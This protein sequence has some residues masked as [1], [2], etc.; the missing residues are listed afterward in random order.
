L[1][2]LPK[3]TDQSLWSVLHTKPRAEKKVA[4]K[5]RGIGVTAYCPTVSKVSQW[6][7]RKK[8][9]QKPALPSMILVKDSSYNDAQ[10]FS[11]NGIVGFMSHK[12]KRAKV[13]QKEVDVLA[14]FLDGKY[15]VKKSS[16]EI[17][18]YIEVPVLKKQ[19]RVE[20]I[21]GASCWVQ[22]ANTGLSVSFSLG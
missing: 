7:D 10:L 11:F 5:L 3:H 4:Q 8:T 21:K 15:T 1:I 9:I 6:S 18:D 16:I 13:S 20:R 19:G 17:G 12:G 2:N 22:L 14:S